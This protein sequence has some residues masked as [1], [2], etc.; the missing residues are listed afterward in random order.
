MN[1]TRCDAKI[2]VCGADTF[3][4]HALPFFHSPNPLSFVFMLRFVQHVSIDL[5][6]GQWYTRAIAA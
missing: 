4:G 6:Q 1:L 3:F 2:E 5:S